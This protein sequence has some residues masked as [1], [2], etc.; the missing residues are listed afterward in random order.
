MKKKIIT[1]SFLFILFLIFTVYHI[2]SN[3]S[4]PYKILQVIEADM[5]YI[6]LNDNNLV[7]EDELIKLQ[8]V[9]AYHPTKNDFA[10]NQAK[11]LGIS[12]EE[13]LKIGFLAKSWA[14]DEL[15]NKTVYITSKLKKYDKNTKYRYA[16]IN[17][18]NKD[19]GEFLLKN[20]L[21]FVYKD[22]KNKNYYA[23]RNIT[24]MKNNAREISKLEFLLVNLK[25]NVAHK[26]NC[27]HAFSLHWGELVLLKDALIKSIPCK[28]C[29]KAKKEEIKDEFNIPKSKNIYKKALYKKFDNVEIYL[30][31]PLEYKKPNIACITP[32]C[33]RIVNE[34]NLSKTSI[35]TALYGIGEQTEIIEA[36]KRAKDRGVKV[37]SVV[38]YSKNMDSIYPN[39]S[40]FIQEF[41][42]KTD[43]NS[44]I[45]HNKFF[46]FDDKKVLTGSANISS[47]GTGGYSANTVLVVESNEIA[48]AYKK[49]FNQMYKGNFSNKKTQ[50][51]VITNNNISAY[52]S[53]KND[54]YNSLVLPQI[55]NAKK[56]IF[57]S[58][59]YLTDLNLINELIAAKKRGVEVLIL[60]DALCANNFKARVAALREAKIPL[61]VENWGGKNHEKTIVIDSSILITGSCNFSKSGFYKND[62]NVLLIKNPQLAS[63]YRDYYLYLFN[64]I[65]R[66]FLKL[67]PRAE[68]I[69]SINSCYDGIDNNFDGKIDAE[70]EGCKAKKIIIF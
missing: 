7:D 45:M 47:S 53:P 21:A 55:K 1:I 30:I 67:I 14:K 44:I 32:V 16:Y 40:K 12:M 57:I 52:F 62:E 56:E 19:L 4:V 11:N 61:I 58:V 27:E 51:D 41:G 13:Y 9:S 35:D 25:S 66:K 42:S 24:Q 5:F 10:I 69:D 31:N 22:A 49:E 70:D 33:K 29:F 36:L 43:K 39:T 48:K 50:N 34:I 64:S 18:N 15:T 59:F 20:G 46:I 68:G 60:M 6:D 37:Q 54:I 3:E 23:I 38:D 17:Y 8:D 2:K 26:L 65:D 63:F 28:I